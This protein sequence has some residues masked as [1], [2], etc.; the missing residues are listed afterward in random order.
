MLRRSRICCIAAA[1][2]L[3]ESQKQGVAHVPTSSTGL[4]QIPPTVVDFQRRILEF[5]RTAFTNAFEMAVRLDDR[6]RDV[7]ER[8][9]DRVPNLPAE[10]K[11]LLDTWNQ[12]TD[13][14]RETFR[15]T[16]DKSFDLIDGYYA[17]LAGTEQRAEPTT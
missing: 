1:D 5:Q 4:F 6:R 7:V 13:R 17:R 12:A 9:L 2:E 8:F 10:S 16:V 11:E 15:A 3:R 14:S